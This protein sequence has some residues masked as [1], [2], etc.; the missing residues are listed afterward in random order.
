MKKNLKGKKFGRLIALKDSNKKSKC[1]SSMWICICQCGK[2][3]EIDIRHLNS[4]HTRSCGCLRKEYRHG[5]AKEIS[6]HYRLYRIW[7]GIKYRCFKPH[8]I[9]YRYYGKKGIKVCFKWENDYLSFKNWALQNGY[10]KNLT[11][12]RIDNNGDYCPENCRWITRAENAK[13]GSNSYQKKNTE[14]LNIQ[15]DLPF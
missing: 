14:F 15:S 12:D 13:K 11:I 8:H 7:I 9:S 2:I 3:T 5:D 6:K 4:N 10:K 1:G